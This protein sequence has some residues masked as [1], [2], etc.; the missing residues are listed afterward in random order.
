MSFPR[1]PNRNSPLIALYFKWS[2]ISTITGLQHLHSDFHKC[3]QE[4]RDHLYDA[5][6]P[7]EPYG[8]TY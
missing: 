7:Y 5:N 3:L 1:H 2:P 8:A 4:L 6:D